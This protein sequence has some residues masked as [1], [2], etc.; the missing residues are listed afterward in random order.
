[1][2]KLLRREGEDPQVSAMF[3]WAVFQVVL[4][5]GAETWVLSAEMSRN[6]EGVHVGFLR[7]MKGQKESGRVMEP[8]E[9]RDWQRFSRK[10]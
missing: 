2:G 6:M 3:Y 5:F 8:E 7:Q 10:P 9:A 4:I 1:M